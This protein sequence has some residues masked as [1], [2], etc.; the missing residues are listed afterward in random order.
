MTE[1]GRRPSVGVCCD[2][3]ILMMLLLLLLLI[4]MMM[5]TMMMTDTINHLNS[6]NGEAHFHGVDGG[7][8]DVMTAMMKTMTGKNESDAGHWSTE[9]SKKQT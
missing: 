6:V 3:V 5:M 4:M 1:G 8:N 9:K 2:L 7:G